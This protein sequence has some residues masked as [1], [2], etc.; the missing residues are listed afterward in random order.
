[1]SK[2][3]YNMYPFSNSYIT[4][5]KTISLNHEKYEFGNIMHVW[6]SCIITPWTQ[7]FKFA[8]ILVFAS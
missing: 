2:R 1:M 7:H 5:S 3:C 4:Q 8:N 6:I